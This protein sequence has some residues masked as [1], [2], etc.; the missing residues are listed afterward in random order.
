MRVQDGFEKSKRLR[1]LRSSSFTR[2]IELRVLG[3]VV[4]VPTQ[5]VLWLKGESY[6]T[7]W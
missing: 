7:R 1:A 6:I 2:T 4:P 3:R 5:Y